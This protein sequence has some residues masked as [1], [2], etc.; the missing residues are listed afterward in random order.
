MKNGKMIGAIGVGGSASES[1]E[2][3]AQAG[4]LTAK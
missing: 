3:F 2:P 4:T 1:D